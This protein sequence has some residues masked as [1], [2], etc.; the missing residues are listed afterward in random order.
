[1]HDDLASAPGGELCSPAVARV[2]NALLSEVREQ[3]NDDQ[4]VKTIHPIWPIEDETSLPSS[5]SVRVLAG[6]LRAALGPR[7]PRGAVAPPASRVT[8]EVA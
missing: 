5:A 7:T 1:L 6:Q 4:I 8:S 2:F 3:L